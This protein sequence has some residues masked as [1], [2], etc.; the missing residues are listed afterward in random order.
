MPYMQNQNR[1]KVISTVNQVFFNILLPLAC[2]EVPF[3]MLTFPP[4]TGGGGGCLPC[5]EAFS[6]FPSTNHTKEIRLLP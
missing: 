4:T 2:K 6:F 5:L 3:P 1:V